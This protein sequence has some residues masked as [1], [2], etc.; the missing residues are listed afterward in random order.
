MGELYLGLISGT[1]MDGVDCVL[2]DIDDAECRIRYA[3]TL[4]YPPE[5]GARLRALVE[6]P[7]VSL[8]EL[9]SLDAAVGRYFA[10]CAVRSLAEAGVAPEAVAAIG[11][12]GQTV[13]HQP[14]GPDAFSMQIGDP[15]VLAAATGITT[16]ADFRRMDMALG[17]QGAPLVPAFHAWRFGSE[18]ETRVVVNIGGIANITVLEPGR[19]PL[20]FDTGPGNSL[21]DLWIGRSRGEPYD[22]EGRFAAAG[23]VDPALLETLRAEPFF[24]APPPKSTGRELFNMEWLSPRLSEHRAADADVQATLAELTATT[25]AAAIAAS[26][27]RCR[28]IVVCGGGAYNTDL[29]GRLRRVSAV[30]V[31][32]SL[33]FG[34]APDWVEAAAF[35]W[36]A[37]ARLRGAAGN[38]PSVTGAR[39]PAILGGV[40]WGRAP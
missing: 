10:E 14:R 19:E 6:R 30:A 3:A 18:A 11:H 29:L 37:R 28:L 15:N 35:A 20:G 12:H 32:S 31:A 25:I 1:S 24:S 8:R 36:L 2:A 26:T 23:Q 27:A 21:L 16:V 38:V 40:Y 33:D 34:L 9:G 7:Q 5:L 22:R 39:R 13:Y 17:G 4:A